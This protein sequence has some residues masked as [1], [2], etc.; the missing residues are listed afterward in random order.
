M[1]ITH[2]DFDNVIDFKDDCFYTLVLEN[3]K[4]YY[5]YVSQFIKQNNGECEDFSLMED[6]KK[7]NFETNVE[8][9][10]GPF[11]FSVNSKKIQNLVYK[12]LALFSQEDER[13][14][15]YILLQKYLTNYVKRLCEYV[16][17][18][19]QI[20]EFDKLEVIK[21]VPVKVEEL[22]NFYE[23]LLNY[24]NCLLE[25]TKVKL[26]IMI[27]CKQMFTNECFVDFK[28]MVEYAGLKVLFVEQS[29]LES[30]LYLKTKTLILDND[31]CEIVKV[32][33]VS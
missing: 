21:S 16:D 15:D 2:C 14:Q 4:N 19:L 20:E 24:V 33:N 18:P 5:K 28:K 30:V 8:I 7:L 32:D 22:N 12:K 11:N 10:T 3:S 23:N 26:I 17:L 27:S 9:I 29:E 1:I 31:G 13:M 25:L 6:Y